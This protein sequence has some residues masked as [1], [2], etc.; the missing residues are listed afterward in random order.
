MEVYR[1]PKAKK[2][3]EQPKAIY[4]SRTRLIIGAVLW[5]LAVAFFG[6]LAWRSRT[7]TGALAFAGVVTLGAAWMF[8]S[9]VR[10]LGSLDTPVLLI[11]RDGI[12]FPDGVL[13]AWADM[14]ENVY[15]HHSYMGLPIM[16]LVQIKTTLKKPRLK[17]LRVSALAMS[18]DEYMALC[19]SYSQGES[20]SVAR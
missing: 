5:S 15:F 8:F 18:S 3:V 6:A 7:E 10:P 19:D 17:K 11:G 4:Y 14:E 1:S 9:C 2:Q 16:K 20:P 13:I 12:R